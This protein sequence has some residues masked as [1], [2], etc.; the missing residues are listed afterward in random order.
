MKQRKK[1]EKKIIYTEYKWRKRTSISKRTLKFIL[2]N[3]SAQTFGSMSKIRKKETDLRLTDCKCINTKWTK[4]TI[5][6]CKIRLEWR[7]NREKRIVLFL[8]DLEVFRVNLHGNHQLKLYFKASFK[9]F[10][11]QKFDEKQKPK[12]KTNLILRSDIAQFVSSVWYCFVIV[13]IM[14]IIASV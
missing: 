3:Y 1:E 7:K 12:K 8:I 14:N 10:C 6:V 4:P 11:K 2:L 13:T 5:R 9:V